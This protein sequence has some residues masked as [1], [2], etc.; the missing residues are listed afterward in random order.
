MKKVEVKELLKQMMDKNKGVEVKRTRVCVILPRSFEHSPYFIC[1]ELG[2]EGSQIGVEYKDKEVYFYIPIVLF[3]KVGI[4]VKSEVKKE[5]KQKEK[6]EEKKEEQK[7]KK[8]ELVEKKVGE[9]MEQKEVEQKV[10]KKE[11]QIKQEPQKGSVKLMVAEGVMSSC[12]NCK[13]IR[14]VPQGWV[15]D[16]YKVKFQIATVY[17]CESFESKRK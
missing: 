3:K 5:E 12:I 13:Y 9:K 2:K 14:P 4:P 1:K 8:E 16:K 10:E 17:R 6:K 11:E 15:C 7:V